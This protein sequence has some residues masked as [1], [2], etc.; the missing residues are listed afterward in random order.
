MKFEN[1]KSICTF[2]HT[3]KEAESIIYYRIYSWSIIRNIKT[4]LSEIYKEAR[5]SSSFPET[6]SISRNIRA[7]Q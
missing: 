1:C 7:M 5:K 4:M 3:Y 2:E 6:E